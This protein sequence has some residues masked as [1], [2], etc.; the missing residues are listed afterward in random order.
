MAFDISRF[1]SEIDSRGGPARPSL[2]EIIISP[3]KD[4]VT[5]LDKGTKIESRIFSFFCITANIPGVNINAIPYQAVGQLPTS[6]P[7]SVINQPVAAV[8]MIDSDHN[9]LNYFHN[10]I[11]KI[12]NHGASNA[13]TFN[14]VDGK[15]PYEFGYKDEYATD[16]TIR[17]Y[18]SESFDNKYYEV[19]LHNAYP[20]TLG[21]LDLGWSNNNSFLTLPVAFVYDKISYSGTKSG[22]PTARNSRGNGLLDRLGAVAGFASVVQQTIDQGVK[23]DTIQDA[24]NRISRTRNSFDNISTRI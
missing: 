5:E 14:E 7:M 4:G 3:I 23:F 9:I 12:V 2:F 17:H 1:K 18:S 20:I 13:G 16:I 21:D 24:I 19:K 6:F 22:T 11:Q 10:W 8:F 15:L